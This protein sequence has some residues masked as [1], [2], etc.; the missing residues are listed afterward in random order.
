MSDK[1]MKAL[2]AAVENYLGDDDSAAVTVIPRNNAPD[3]ALIRAD[4][5]EALKLKAA[6]FDAGNDED[7]EED[8]I[9]LLGKE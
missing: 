1:A 3:M 2:Q 4:V 7:L 9:T 5:L 8:A 6:Q